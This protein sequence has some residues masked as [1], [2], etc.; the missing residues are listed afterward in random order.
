[1]RQ[2]IPNTLTLLNA[3]SGVAS[4]HFSLSKNF[5]LSIAFLV[6]ALLFDTF[7]GKMSR[8][9]KA[10]S[11]MGAELDSLSDLVSFGVAPWIFVISQFELNL[12]FMMLGIIFICAGAYRL[13]G[14]NAGRR[15]TKSGFIG[16]PIP[17]NAII[18]P[19]IYLLYPNIKIY[20]LFLILSSVLMI[21]RIKIK[22]IF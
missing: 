16:M 20:Y 18:F 2:K 8:I 17:M 12:V 13:A 3:A 22:R 21:S 9:L 14:Y 10:E 7:D 19:M 4:I 15:K 5:E 11:F 6:L 1:M